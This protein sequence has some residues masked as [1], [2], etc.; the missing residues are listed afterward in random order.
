MQSIQPNHIESVT[1]LITENIN[2]KFGRAKYL[3]HDVIIMR[4]N[5]YINMTKLCE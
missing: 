5:G 4:E 1:S 2:E 3:D